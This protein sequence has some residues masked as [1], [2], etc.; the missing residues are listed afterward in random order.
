MG[1]NLICRVRYIVVNFLGATKQDKLSDTRRSKPIHQYLYTQ[2]PIIVKNI[3]NLSR[4]IKEL[5]PYDM[6]SNRK[7]KYFASRSW[8]L[9]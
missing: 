7:I 6:T 4:S 1:G 2:G 9:I 8:A 3:P 5:L